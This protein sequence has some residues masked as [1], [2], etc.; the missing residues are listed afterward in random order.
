MTTTWRTLACVT[1]VCAAAV[2]TGCTDPQES[3]DKARSKAAA[4][5]AQTLLCRSGTQWADGDKDAQKIMQPAFDALIGKYRHDAN[6]SVR[7][8]AR[9][10]ESL[11]DAGDSTKNAAVAALRAQCG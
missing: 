2:L 3:T 7:E 5:A 10:A 8:L 11:M 6:E 9:A 4:A 1:A